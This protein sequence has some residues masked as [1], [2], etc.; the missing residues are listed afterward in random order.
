M[1]V[2]FAVL[3]ISRAKIKLILYAKILADQVHDVSDAI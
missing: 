1:A 2:F 3:E